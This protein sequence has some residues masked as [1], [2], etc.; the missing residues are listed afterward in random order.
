MGEN[1]TNPREV[2]KGWLELTEKTRAGRGEFVRKWCETGR[3]GKVFARGE[4][5]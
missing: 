1:E 2:I 5:E 4:G 3:A